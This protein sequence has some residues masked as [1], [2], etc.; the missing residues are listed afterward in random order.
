MAF[1]L[2]EPRDFANDDVAGS[3]AETGSQLEIVGRA[4]KW[5]KIETAE[6]FRVL[7]GRADAGS[8]ILMFHRV[9]NDNEMGGDLG[10]VAF[11]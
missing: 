4:K 1:Q 2:E 5:A 7:R 3:E 11:G 9:S 6:D 8:Q 10:G